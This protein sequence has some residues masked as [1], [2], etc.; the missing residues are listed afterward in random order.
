MGISGYGYG[1]TV[2]SNVNGYGSS[3]LGALFIVLILF[4]VVVLAY[5]VI[6]YIF[7]A[8]AFS[9]IAARRGV[10][11]PWL[12]WI[13]GAN[14]WLT[15]KIA[16]DYCEKA[17]G[18][19]TNYARNLIIFSIANVCLSFPLGF[20]SG[21]TPYISNTAILFFFL[22][23]ELAVLA[24]S[25]AFLVYQYIVYYKV[26]KSCAPEKATLYL[27]LS[28]IFAVIMPFLLFSVSD[29]DDGLSEGYVIDKESF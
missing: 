16:E 6:A 15:G 12:A 21:I 8:K 24:F 27:I 14:M 20:V 10:G 3:G 17:E 4:Y 19:T 22:L 23:I 9:K 11:K 7:E 28:I 1:E 13:P 25:V 29:R 5:A 2:I 26:L 18:R